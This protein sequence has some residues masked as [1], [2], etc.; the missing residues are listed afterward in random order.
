MTSTPVTDRSAVNLQFTR[1]SKDKQGG[2]LLSENFTQVMKQSSNDNKDKTEVQTLKE[3][4]EVK[5][6][7]E[8]VIKWKLKTK[9]EVQTSKETEVQTTD[10][11][12]AKQLE[13]V[14]AT[15]E[16]LMK[17]LAQ[18]LGISEE[19][20]MKAMEELSYQLQDLLQ[21]DNLTNLFMNLSEE[22]DMLSLVTNG[23]LYG[24]F[25]E[26]MEFF[27]NV[28][29]ELAD[30]LQIPETE[31]EQI[32]Q[33]VLKDQGEVLEDTIQ[34]SDSKTTKDVVA[35]TEGVLNPESENQEEINTTETDPVTSD[36]SKTDGEVKP[37]NQNFDQNDQGNKQEL[38]QE[39]KR[40]ESQQEIPF[41][42][43]NQ[44]TGTPILNT[45]ENQTTVDLLKQ[46]TAEDL[47][48]QLTDAVKIQ[49]KP[50]V[51]TL[52]MQLNPANLG[53]VHLQVASK[54]GIITAQITV[55]N[56]VVKEAMESQMVQLKET[57][58]EQ[59]LK[60][61]SVEVAVNNHSFERNLEQQNSNQEDGSANQKKQTR[62]INLNELSEE[63]L[64]LL[65][66]DDKIVAD[67]IKING[68]SV[69]YTA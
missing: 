36:L 56:N 2:A 60:V 40:P 7:N 43:Q 52:E 49:M 14:V 29:A 62:K 63:E 57:L 10:D 54:E 58:I 31:L 47:M 34:V 64:E 19:E 16:K 44:T 12:S 67:L 41:P 5:S 45:I 53:N 61:E 33:T 66:G 21:T 23:E 22:P 25:T 59:G 24:K 32:L 35:T 26:L 3:K 30:Y 37:Q 65:T 51:T 46:K 17:K 11:L 13:E 69:D 39:L 27:E 9:N 55:S 48:R 68:N 18:V 50:D 6:E 4:P 38:K 28:K 8:S 1:I 20:V 15:G 42:I